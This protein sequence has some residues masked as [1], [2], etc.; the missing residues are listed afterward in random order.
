LRKNPVA[1]YVHLWQADSKPATNAPT[2]SE[3]VKP[4]NAPIGSVD[5]DT[6][7]PG[8]ESQCEPFNEVIGDKLQGG[9]SRQ[10]I[11]Q[12]LRDEHGF[13]GSYYSVRRFVKRLGADRPIPFRRM[14]CMPGEQA[15][16]DFGTGAPIVRPDSKRKRPH[17]F[18]IV[19][20]FSRK[21]YSE[22]VYCQTTDNF[23]RCLENTFWHFGGV[24]KTLIIDYVPRHIIDVMCPNR[25]CGQLN[26]FLG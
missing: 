12:D 19:L 18:R 11:Y 10:R 5:K 23:I 20:S 7:K 16:I 22:A 4:A 25:L 26:S 2:G 8:P 1:R 14:E 15:Q 9:L 6:Q 24:P 13:K 3:G 21:G 17:V